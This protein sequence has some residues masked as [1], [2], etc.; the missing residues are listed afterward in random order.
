MSLLLDALK[1]AGAHRKAVSEPV[2]TKV[3]L[4][5]DT[6]ELE[7][8]LNGIDENIIDTK[9]HDLK[10]QA[11]S[12]EGGL[13]NS[14]SEMAEADF[15]LSDGSDVEVQNKPAH[16]EV[17][18]RANFV[19]QDDKAANA[20]FRNRTKSK[21]EPSIFVISLI[22]LLLLVLLVIGYF[23]WSLGN[24]NTVN[25][26][27]VSNKLRAVIPLSMPDETTTTAVKEKGGQQLDTQ[28]IRQ[29]DEYVSEKTRLAVAENDQASQLSASLQPVNEFEVEPESETIIEFNRISISKRHIPNKV[30]ERLLLAMQ[31]I[32]A[33]NWQAAESHY[34]Q[35][36][37]ES[38]ENVEALT[39]LGDAMVI[40]GKED[41]AHSLYLGVLQ[42][43]PGN[44]NASVGL[45]N[46]KKDRT[47]LPHGS[48]LKQLIV[49][50]PNE[51]FLHANL[52]DYYALREEWSAAQAAYFEAFS[53]N[54]L[55]ADYAFNLA[56][57]LDQMG[58]GVIALRYYKQ[59]LV[60]N[61]NSAGRFDVKGLVTR[62]SDL[63]GGGQ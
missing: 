48:D 19:A 57:S 12:M 4:S 40:L 38:P 60:L 59:A 27:S 7:L 11:I 21:F 49:E 46:L 33:G 16:E 10:K 5:G 42:K 37:T 17:S 9:V 43:M 61:K 14:E 50:N 34:R 22:L 58:K 62:I 55:S 32:T 29:A 1:E 63:S 20:V 56:V 47:S 25:N 3:E 30:R 23:L 44:I 6:L 35:V 52:G 36:L 31:A 39:G 2:E 41:I 18:T 54:D 8:G 15:P 28:H 45:L 13:G 26:N 53:K 24:I 51:A